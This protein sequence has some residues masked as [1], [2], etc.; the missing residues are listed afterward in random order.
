MGRPQNE[1]GLPA[2]LPPNCH[3]K[4]HSFRERRRE[5][6]FDRRGRALIGVAEQVAVNS[7][8]HGWVAVPDPAADCD[9]VEPRGDQLADVRV[10]QRM[11]GDLREF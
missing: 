3:R 1:S 11:Q 6:C 4:S 2:V 9:H 10:P 7:Q 8:R 5:S